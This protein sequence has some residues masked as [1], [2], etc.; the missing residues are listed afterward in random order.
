[1]AATLDAV[2]NGNANSTSVTVS[3][4]CSGTNRL[5]VVGIAHNTGAVS[6]VTYNGVAMT[7]V[8]SKTQGNSISDLYYLL[9]P[10]VGTHDVVV[11][12]GSSFNTFV[13]CA[14]FNGI[15]SVQPDAT[16]TNSA[17][18]ANSCANTLTTTTDHAM[19]IAAY[20]VD[21]YPVTSI[22]NGTLVNMWMGY[23]LDVTPAA[24]HSLTGNSSGG[25]NTWATVGASFKPG[26]QDEG[27]AS[28]IFIS[29]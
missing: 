27:T 22:T 13:E 5:L 8:D 14:S 17:T 29:S 19:H 16:V 24:S 25:N 21:A 1:M 4:V 6:G 23:T 12:N 18:G 2:S 3:H 26:T 20:S 11:S 10:T 15:G 7:K 28:Y 9:A